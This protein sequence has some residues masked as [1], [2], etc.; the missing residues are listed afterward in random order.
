MLTF[1]HPELLMDAAPERR[2]DSYTDAIVTLLQERAAG[3]DIRTDTLAVVEIAAGMWSRAFASARVTPETP[4]TNAL[5]PSVLA[6]IGR[7][8][9]TRGEYVGELAVVAGRVRVLEAV[10]WNVAGDLGSWVYECDFAGPSGYQSRTLA[11]ERVMHPRIGSDPGKPW[12]GVGPL[13]RALT[14]LTLAGRL[15]A[16]LA[17]EAGTPTGTL[18]PQPRNSGTD[19][20]ALRTDIASLK[21]AVGLPETTA[22]GGQSAD[23]EFAPRRDWQE[24]KLGPKPYETLIPLRDSVSSHLL[25]AA[26]VPASLIA[27]GD[28]TL[29]REDYRRFLHSTIV[30]VG[31]VIA[32]ELA[33]K[34]DTPGLAFDFAELGAADIAGR[35]RAFQSLVGGGMDVDRALAA[36]GLL[37]QEPD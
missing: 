19:T 24:L 36:T 28:G 1:R 22:A 13:K 27:R 32:G 21:G 33:D 34:L 3:L 2:D 5:S 23:R 4:F 25:A 20:A 9:L 16:A 6:A 29:A 11:S 30:P 10:S 8:L 18:I 7:A 26:G 37:V 31:K 17:Y 14:S 12:A 35:A 15:E